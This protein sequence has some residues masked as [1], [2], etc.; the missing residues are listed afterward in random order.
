M[1]AASA[2]ALATDEDEAIVEVPA[3]G[4][5]LD[6]STVAF[7]RRL[8]ASLPRLEAAEARLKSCASGE[9][10]LEALLVA[11]V[12]LAI[13]ERPMLLSLATDVLFRRLPERSRQGLGITSKPEDNKSF[14]ACY[15]KVRYLFHAL[16]AT[17]DPSGLPKNKV[18]TQEELVQATKEM[19]E[20]DRLGARARLEA[21]VNDVV[22]SSISVLSRSERRGLSKAIGLDATCLELWSRGPSKTAG[23]CAS[24]PDGAWYVRDGDHHYDE[25]AERD[26]LGRRRSKARPPKWALEGTIATSAPSAPGRP[27][28]APNLVLGFCLGRPG[29]DPGGT[30]T[31]VLAGVVTEGHEPGFV[32]ADRAYSAALPERYHLPVRALGFRPVMDY[33][34]DDLGIQANAAGAILVE[35]SWYCPGM[36]APLIEATAQRRAGVIEEA[37]Y[38]ERIAARRPFALQKKEGPDQDGYERW[39]CPAQ[40]DRP[41]VSCPLREASGAVLDGRA[42]VFCPP[43][44]P[45]ALCRQ[46]SVT[47][48]PDVGARQRQ[49]LAFADEEWLEVYPTLRNSIEGLNGF[50]KD[51]AH[52]GIGDPRRRRV[53]GIAAQSV[54]VAFM[55]LGA[56]LR[57][58]RSW[59][60]AARVDGEGN[61]SAPA[62]PRRAR[63]RRMSLTDHRPTS[64]AMDQG[65]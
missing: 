22:A 57:R 20:E 34:I 55:L 16:L 28:P 24:D 2:S 27:R 23:T 54:L 4:S 1:L 26:K 51:T 41:K 46:C 58:I 33:R 12:V 56:N 7:A 25:R 17:M 35:G 19:T 42:K 5:L 50:A 44:D 65:P 38:T 45:P 53:R 39:A 61:L 64:E 11:V 9:V 37:T 13:E 14:A 36:P 10:R 29:A 6:E 8:V 40:G 47:I 62:H 18:M 32:G 43:V 59:R 30:G 63:R 52:E 21:F 49:G 60:E 48:P 3:P 15:R 31:R